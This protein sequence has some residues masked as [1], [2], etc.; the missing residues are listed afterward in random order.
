MSIDKSGLHIASS[1]V[2]EKLNKKSLSASMVTALNENCSASWLANTF[3]I[4]EVIDT[5]PDN[6]ASRGSL[7][8]KVME[9]FFALPKEERTHAAM[10]KTA[11]SVLYSEE[12][13]PLSKSKEAVKW[14][15]DA[16][17]SYY[18]MGGSPQKVEISKI[19][20]DDREIVG[21][22]AFV[23]GRI[24]NTQREIL[25]FIDQVVDDLKNPGSVVVQD[26][27][28]GAKAKHWNPKTVSTEGLAEQRQQIIYSMLLGQ[29]GV[30]VSSARLVYPVA[31]EVV[32]VNLNDYEM[33]NRVVSNVEE[34]DKKLTH[35][36]E[37]NTFEFSPSF[38]C[39]WCPLAKICPEADIK[40]YKK[41]QDAIKTQP[42]LDDFKGTIRI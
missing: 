40:P 4:P 7:F 41:M 36:Q 20:M 28:T 5:P 25:G 22:E 42:T 10:R 23:K 35:L 3:V 39:A 18:I 9:D 34:V 30:N 12:F 15:K 6:A 2:N 1:D 24:G 11:K 16:I 8:H 37:N 31:R 33:K 13:L 19:K 26:W 17:N 32:N 29:K 21:L 38:L 27:K 14:L